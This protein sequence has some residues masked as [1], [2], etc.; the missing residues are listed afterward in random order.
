MTRKKLADSF[1]VD[2]IMPEIESL[3][4][5]DESRA[6]TQLSQEYLQATG[7]P[8]PC[9]IPLDYSYQQIS[10]E[11]LFKSAKAAIASGKPIIWR[12]ILGKPAHDGKCFY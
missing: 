2:S 4:D 1:E 11:D 6:Y 3:D 7:E 8:M 5:T 10:D 12:K 9:A